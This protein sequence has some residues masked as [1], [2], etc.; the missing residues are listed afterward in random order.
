MIREERLKR[1]QERA[2]KLGEDL[3]DLQE[4][5]EKQQ[6]WQRQQ[7]LKWADR[8]ASL[9]TFLMNLENYLEMDDEINGND[10]GAA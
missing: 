5:V 3:R 6:A 2:R 1:L 8:M 7:L 9:L 4:H 10:D